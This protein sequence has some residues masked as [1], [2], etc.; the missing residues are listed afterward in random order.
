MRSM[1]AFGR[2]TGQTGGR[3]YVCEIKSVNNRFLDCTVKLPRQMSFLEKNVLELVSSRGISRGKVDIYVSV[4]DRGTKGVT[5]S[6]DTEYADTYVAALNLL[7]ERYC[8]GS[9]PPDLSLIA[10][11]PQVFMSVKAADDEDGM[12]EELS[13]Y[14]SSALDSFIL[15]GEEEGERLKTDLLSKIRTLSEMTS[16]IVSKSEANAVSYR[17]KLEQRL[18]RTLGE[19]DIKADEN[20]ILTEVALFCDKIAVDEE[21]TRLG[22]HFEAFRTAL[23]S[24]EPVGRR[25]D[26]LVQEM[27]RE[28]NTIGS[29]S[30]D[31]AIASV[32]VSAK[33]ELEKIREQIQNLE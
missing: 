16:E 22:S 19:L 18:R 24:R 21:T 17:E 25:L 31:A 5:A 8:P 20:R 10:S 30:C 4:E 28:I 14:V 23:G 3:F 26:F 33:C 15:S 12:W 13:P 9:P 32:V 7:R 2:A 27:N 11:N 6:V 1:T 29:K